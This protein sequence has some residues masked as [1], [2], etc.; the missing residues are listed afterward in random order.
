MRDAKIVVVSRVN[1]RQSRYL[2][3]HKRVA[4]YIIKNYYCKL[5]QAWRGG[6][7]CQDEAVPLLQVRGQR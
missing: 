3:I 1:L 2:T 4:N 5:L 6:W 7:C